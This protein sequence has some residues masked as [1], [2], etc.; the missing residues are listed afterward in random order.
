MPHIHTVPNQHDMTISAYILLNDGEEWKCLVHWHK[1]SGFYMQIGGHIELDQ[2][3][4]QAVVAEVSEE[5][6]YDFEQLMLLQPSLF[7]AKKTSYIR[8]PVPFAMNT[9]NVGDTHYHSD[10]CYGFVASGMPQNEVAEGESGEL[11]YVSIDELKHM[12]ERGESL[13][14][15]HA[16]Y[17]LLLEMIKSMVQLPSTKFSLEKPKET[18]FKYKYG[19]ASEQRDATVVEQS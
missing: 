17:V 2:T 12:A 1:K 8:H 18:A 9:H 11:K 13:A 10:M 14:D 5:T 3:P 15:V 7:E 6:G 16:N 4:W 19:S